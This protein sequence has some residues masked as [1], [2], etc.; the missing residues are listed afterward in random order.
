M[1]PTLRGRLRAAGL[2]FTSTVIVASLV[3]AIVFLLWYPWPY[4]EVSGGVGLFLLVVGVDVVLGPLIT[5]VVF[6]IRKPRAEL[7]RDMSVVVVLQLAGLIYGAHTVFE[8][9]PVVMALEG[10]RFR[11]V[12][13]ADVV[14]DEL[15]RAPASLRSLSLTGPTL[16]ST[17][18]PKEGDEKFDAIA[19]ALSGADL[20]MRPSYWL[21]WDAKARAQAL[22]VGKP[23]TELLARRAAQ[24]AVLRDAVAKTGRPIEQLIY[25][26]L[27]ARRTDWSV[28]LDKTTGDPVGFAP[29]DGF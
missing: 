23:V 3:A 1:T 29:V 11:T 21:P 10:D 15:P 7:W 9:R 24:A 28:L 20:G 25:I 8:A 17:R 6:D 13:A 18:D 2:H 22:K 12:I 16:V 4:S 14:R 19:S 26:P 27:L 5:L